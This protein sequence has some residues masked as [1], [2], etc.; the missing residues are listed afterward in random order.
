MVARIRATLTSPKTSNRYRL[1]P[2]AWT[3]QRKLPFLTVVTVRLSGHKR[4]LQPALNRVFQALGRVS[5]VP[6]ASAYSQARQQLHPALFQHL[7]E[8]VSADFYRLY[9]ADG[10]VKRWQGRRLLGVEGSVFNVPDTPETR[11]CYSVQSHPYP[12]GARVPARGRV[13]YDLLNPVALSAGV[14]KKPAEKQFLF[15]RH[16]SVT[17][18]GDVMILDRAYA[19]YRVLALLQAHRRDFVLRLPRRSFRAVEPFGPYPERDQIVTLTLPRGQRRF[20]TAQDLAPSLQVRLI[21]VDL[22]SGEQE[23]LATSLLDAPAYPYGELQ[24]LYGLRWGVETSYDRLKNICELERFSGRSVLSLEQDFY[25]VSFLATFESVLSKEAA[26]ELAQ[27]SATKQRQYEA[28]VNRTISYLALVDQTVALLLDTHVTVEE[29]L[30]TLHH[31]FKTSPPPA[32][33]G[34]QVPRKVRSA[35]HQLW[36]LRYAKRLIA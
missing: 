19:D 33:L 25:G 16:L 15:T 36:F 11:Q 13:C 2:T 34:R 8:V 4:I 27:K 21:K 30:A 5:E 29:T 7:H 31:L 35:A 18:V 3:R 9:G 32:R 20:V 12:D 23:V 14:G 28:R 6:T 17:A 24:R 10:E 22:P 26:A 1:R